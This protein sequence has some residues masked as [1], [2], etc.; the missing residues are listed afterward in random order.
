MPTFRSG[1]IAVAVVGRQDVVGRKSEINPVV[2][3]GAA[4]VAAQVIIG[5][6][7]KRNADIPIWLHCRSCCW[8]S[9]CCWKKKRDQSRRSDWRSCCCRSSYYWKTNREKCRHSDLVALP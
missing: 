8:P 2:L 1:C 7:I 4:V 9:G 6:R 3:I 5:R